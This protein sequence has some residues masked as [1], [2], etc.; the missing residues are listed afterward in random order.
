MKKLLLTLS[1]IASF[2]LFA[3]ESESLSF[4]KTGF[5]VGGKYL[6]LK[7]D[8]N[9][10]NAAA[11]SLM[12]NRTVAAGTFSSST[13]TEDTNTHGFGITFGKQFTVNHAAEILIGF[14]Q[15]MHGSKLSTFTSGEIFR[16]DIELDV[17]PVLA[18]YQG[19]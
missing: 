15:S 16:S 6:Y 18:Q 1:L 8:T 2:A 5:Y 9:A 10:N 19:R 11:D 13:A 14:S 3:E 12:T 17:V 7:S 4:P